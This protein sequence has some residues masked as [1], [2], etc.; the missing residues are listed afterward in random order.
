MF[1][2]AGGAAGGRWRWGW[3][4]AALGLLL[5]HL[6]VV[7]PLVLVDRV[8]VWPLLAVG[9]AAVVVAAQP[10]T[11]VNGVRDRVRLG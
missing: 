10:R 4:D 3:V 6:A 8:A 5:A 11:R 2:E 1:G 9:V 7:P